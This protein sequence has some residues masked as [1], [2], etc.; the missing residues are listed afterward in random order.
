[1]K[2]AME[3]GVVVHAEMMKTMTKEQ[4]AQFAQQLEAAIHAA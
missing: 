3:H 1:M 4:S 2:K